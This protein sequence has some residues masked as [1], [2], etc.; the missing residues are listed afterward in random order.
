MSM[1]LKLPNNFLIGS[2][3]AA[4]QIE[5]AVNEDGR[6]PSIWDDFCHT[7][8]KI[9][10]GH[11]GDIAC[12]HYHRY[13]EDVDIM[14]K[15]NLDAYRF[16]MAWSRILP[17]GTGKVNPQGLAFYDRLID[18]LLEAGI[19]PIQPCFTG[20]HP[21]PSLKR[22]KDLLVAIC[23]TCLPTM[24]IFVL[25]ISVTGSKTGLP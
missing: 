21:L 20:I 15:M 4:Y 11:T 16:S 9:D 22:I 19:T 14:K 25:L 5:G 6:K 17:E 10:N 7:K 12:N 24:Q 18:S 13:Q 2:A 3:T 1:E 8:G 23:V